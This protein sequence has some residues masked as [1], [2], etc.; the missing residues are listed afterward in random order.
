MVRGPKPVQAARP[1]IK[2]SRRGPR[3]PRREGLGFTEPEESL[4]AMS[5]MPL[6]VPLPSLIP[7]AAALGG[8]LAMVACASGPQVATGPQSNPSGARGLLAAAST[9]G[10]VPLVIA[11]VPAI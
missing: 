11:D 10:P 8:L 5:T 7:R 2:G 9:Q 4:E 1:S 6:H 3:H